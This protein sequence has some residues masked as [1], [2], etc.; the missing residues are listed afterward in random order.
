MWAIFFP[1]PNYFNYFMFS[2]VEFF[3]VINAGSNMIQRKNHYIQTEYGATEL[4]AFKDNYIF[5]ETVDTMEVNLFFAS[6]RHLVR[7]EYYR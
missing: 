3:L 7:E 4:I 6:G 5:G 2:A 1:D